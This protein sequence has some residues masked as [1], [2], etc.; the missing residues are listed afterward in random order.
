MFGK[1]I[2]SSCSF[3]M[4]FVER[5]VHIV[6]DKLTERRI[7]MKQIVFS[8]LYYIGTASCGAQ[9]AQKAGRDSSLLRTIISGVANG[10]GGGVVRDIFILCRT[11]VLFEVSTLPAIFI[12]VTFSLIYHYMVRRAPHRERDYELW[13]NFADSLG[14]STFII[15][16]I[17]NAIHLPIFYQILSGITTALAGGI[18]ATI[19]NQKHISFTLYQPIIMTGTLM[20][21]L[22]EKAYA[23]I[24]VFVLFLYLFSATQLCNHEVNRAVC[25][26]LRSLFYTYNYCQVQCIY[27]IESNF[28]FNY[29]DVHINKQNTKG[30]IN[31]RIFIRCHRF[32]F[33]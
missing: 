13:T 3:I 32:R 23:S 19:I 12:A 31:H 20:Y 27:L 1:S 29:R 4:S 30:Y 5:S 14:V 28:H 22:L 18:I 6:A 25:N 9:G 10:F 26:A 11:P 16:G 33:C 17:N 15:C 21:F 8:L 7:I 24:A 2:A